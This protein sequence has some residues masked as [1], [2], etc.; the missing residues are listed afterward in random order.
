MIQPVESLH[1][2]GDDGIVFLA[3]GRLWL[4]RP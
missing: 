4:D 1:F 3:G 2:T